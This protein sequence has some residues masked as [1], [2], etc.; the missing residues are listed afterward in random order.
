MNDEIRLVKTDGGLELVK[1][2][3]GLEL[4]K[5][6]GG[7]WAASIDGLPA[8]GL[9][10]TEADAIRRLACLLGDFVK[11]HADTIAEYAGRLRALGVEVNDPPTEQHPAAAV[12]DHFRPT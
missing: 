6:D 3:G 11:G 4:V 2:D 8:C 1:T 9:G 5:T 12:L 10:S 7:E